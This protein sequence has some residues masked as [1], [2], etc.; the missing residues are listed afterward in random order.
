MLSLF[1]NDIAVRQTRL[2]SETA[3]VVLVDL[4]KLFQVFFCP[5]V[6]VSFN[7]VSSET[8]KL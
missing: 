3:A 5:F 4:K 8:F 7:S 6:A 2:Q 1:I